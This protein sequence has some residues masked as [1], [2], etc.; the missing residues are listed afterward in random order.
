VRSRSRRLGVDEDW[1]SKFDV[2][3]HVPAGA[4]PKEGPSA[5]ITMAT[6]LASALSGRPVRKDVA[7]TGEITLRGKVL[8]VGGLKEKVIAA[9]R[10][11]IR[12]VILPKENERDMHEIPENVRRALRFRF[13]EHMD[14][15]LEEALLPAPAKPVAPEPPPAALEVPR[16]PVELPQQAPPPPPQA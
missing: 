3:I 7:M 4:Q 15:V 1:Y 6:A 5:G 14:E 11:G 13:V 8:P 2:H 10:A 16:I 9:H 12:T